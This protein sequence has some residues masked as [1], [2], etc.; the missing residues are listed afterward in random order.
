MTRS[1]TEPTSWD[2][3]LLGAPDAVARLAEILG[4]EFE[5]LKVRDLNA[6]EAI[7]EEKNVLLQQLAQ[8]AEWAA[9]QNPVPIVW[10][11]LQ[12][13]LRQSKQ[14]HLRNIQLLQRQLQ[15][16]KGTLQ[17]LQGE[18]A[19]PSVDLYDRMGQ[20]ARRSGAWGYQLA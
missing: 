15:A 2:A 11:Q 12:D 13:S 9:P 3:A 16:V 5:A 18:S 8:L 19:A 1:D 17:A 6:F 7:Q 20:I 4:L 10:Q 14:D